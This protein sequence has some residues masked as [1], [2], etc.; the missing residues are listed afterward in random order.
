MRADRL[1]QT[2]LLLQARGRVTAAELAAELEVS[3]ATARRDLEALST[4]GVPVYAQ[5][6]RRGGW[7]LVGGART[8][9]SGLTAAEARAVFE[10]LG[11]N[12]PGADPVLASALRKVL[13]ALPEPF[14]AP[15]ER[16]R[17]AVA[18]DASRW[19]HVPAD[20]P[21]GVEVLVEALSAAVQVGF[22][23]RNRAGEVSTV[24]VSPIGVVD[25]DGTWYL[26]A[27]RADGER[28]TY[29]VDRMT[30][31]SKRDA[32]STV[33]APAEVAEQWDQVVQDVEAARSTCAATIRVAELHAGVVRDQFGS[34]HVE[35]V[36]GPDSRGRVTLSVRAQ[37]P[38]DIARQLAG[39]GAD[40]ELLEPDS[41]RAELARLA[42]ELSA[43]YLSPPTDISSEAP[44]ED[45]RS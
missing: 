40:A 5:P 8:D 23:Y 12:G 39:W 27:Q 38:L 42:V 2:V 37:I 36:A 17:A 33:D 28:R 13:R 43:A 19:G 1:I 26:L 4:A 21:E 14:R 41:V 31:V 20:R 9:L 11:R 24:Q 18:V 3:V 25:K 6:G 16:A 32:A 7:S 22:G 15:A 10:Q 44:P 29:R 34:R 30:G 35:Q 45:A